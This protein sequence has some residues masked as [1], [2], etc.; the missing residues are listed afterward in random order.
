MSSDQYQILFERYIRR[1]DEKNKVIEQVI[2]FLPGTNLSVLDVGCGTGVISNSVARQGNRVTA[3]DIQ[4]AFKKES[5]LK[6][7]PKF[8]QT[9]IFNFSTQEK[10]DVIIAAYVF[11]EVP[12]DKWS[13]LISRFFSMLNNNGKIFV[14]DT[15][16]D[17]PFDNMYVDF[18]I[19]ENPEKEKALNNLWYDFLNKNNFTYTQN[20][21]ETHVKAQ[22]SEEMY[23]ALEFFFKGKTGKIYKEEKSRFLKYFSKKRDKNGLLLTLHHSLDVIE[24]DR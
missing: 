8:I 16:N 22:N 19:H 1:S 6:N 5:T 4:N 18:D 9:D 17:T 21:F 23:E 20:I 15:I 2:K 11:W 13:E 24:K 3:I 12:F 7:P 10:Y 14:I